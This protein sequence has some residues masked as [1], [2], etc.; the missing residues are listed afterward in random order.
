MWQLFISW[1]FA[2][3]LIPIVLGIEASA[4]D[5]TVSRSEY[6]ALFTFYN[7]T[8]GADWLWLNTTKYGPVWNFQQSNG[9]PVSNPCSPSWQGLQCVCAAG[10]CQVE[11]IALPDY[12]L[13]GF[14]A[15]SL[16]DFTA[17]K[18]LNL[19]HNVELGGYFPVAPIFPSTIESID[20]SKTSL[21][22]ALPSYLW[23]LSHLK[24]LRISDTNLAGQLSPNVA[25]LTSIVE[26]DLGRNRLDGSIPVEVCQLAT[27]ET[28]KLDHNVLSGTVFAQ[29]TQ[30]TR[31]KHLHWQGNHISGSL[32]PALA[33]MTALEDFNVAYNLINGTLPPIGRPRTLRTLNVGFNLLTG[34]LPSYF[35]T[36]DG[37]VTLNVARNLLRSSAPSFSVDSSVVNLIFDDNRFTGTIPDCYYRHMPRLS[38]L[39]LQNNL[40]HGTLPAAI[41]QLTALRNFYVGNNY[42]VSSLPA[43]LFTLTSLSILSLDYNFFNGSLSS[44]VSRLASLRVLNVA[45][46]EMTGTVPAAIGRLSNM[47]RL[48]LCGNHFHGAIP[49]DLG[50]LRLLRYL[51]LNANL[52]TGTIPASFT[53]LTNL[54]WFYASENQLS[55]DL[56]AILAAMPKLIDVVMFSNAF[57][58]PLPYNA[59]W[60]DL[61]SLSFGFNYLT[62]SLRLTA[63]QVTKLVY[64]DLSKNLLSTTLPAWTLQ[65]RHLSYFYMNENFVHGTLPQRSVTATA[66][67][68]LWMDGNVLTGTLPAAIGN[69]SFLQLLRVGSNFL[70]GTVP[71]SLATLRFMET[72]FLQSN[73]FSGGI[74]ALCDPAAQRRLKYIDISDNYFA[75]SLPPAAFNSTSLVSFAAATNCFSGS[76]P[77][78]LCLAT[79]LE[80]L[81]LD[82][83]ST[84]T[85]CQ[86]AIFA[87][88][89]LWKSSASPSAVHSTSRPRLSA[90]FVLTK[91]LT[92]GVPP[93]LFAMPRL[94]LLHLSGNALT[95]SLPP[96]VAVSPSLR[97]VSVANNQLS[98][99][100]PLALQ[101]QAFQ[102]LDVSYNKFSGTLS[103]A[104]P[105]LW[106]NGSFLALRNRLSGD[107]PASLRLALNVSILEGNLFS[108]DSLRRDLPA[109]DPKAASYSCGSD[110][111]NRALILWVCL[112]P[113]L[114][115]LLALLDRC[116]WRIVWRP[117]TKATAT[118]AATVA[119]AWSRLRRVVRLLMRW[120]QTLYVPLQLLLE[121]DEAMHR[122]RAS[123][124]QRVGS[125]VLRSFIAPLAPSTVAGTAAAAPD[126][127]SSAREDA[128]SF[129][130]SDNSESSSVSALHSYVWGLSPMLLSGLAPG[131]GLFFVFVALLSAVW[132]RVDYYKRVILRSMY[133]YQLSWPQLSFYALFA[134]VDMAILLS[135][136]VL[137]VLAVPNARS[138]V[139]FLSEAGLAAFKVAWNELVVIRGFAV[140]KTAFFAYVLGRGRA[141]TDATD[142]AADAASAA[143][144]LPAARHRSVARE[145]L[146]STTQ[147]RR[148][149]PQYGRFYD[150]IVQ[151][152]IIIANLLLMPAVATAVAN[153]NCFYNV[154]QPPATVA[155]G[156]QLAACNDVVEFG[157]VV[158]CLGRTAVYDSVTYTA[159]FLYTY[160]CSSFLVI[161]YASVYV[162][163]VVLVTVLA[164]EESLFDKRQLIIRLQSYLALLLIFGVLFPPMAVVVCVGA[165]MMM[166]FE[167]VLV[168]HVLYTH[169]QR[170]G[171]TDADGD[172]DVEAATRLTDGGADGAAERRLRRQFAACA[173]YRLFLL[174]ENA[175]VLRYLTNPVLVWMLLTV[176]S[177]I[178]GYLL[179]D[180]MGDALV[181]DGADDGSATA[182]AT[183]SHGA[184][185]RLVVTLTALTVLWP[186]LLLLV[187]LWRRWR[188]RWRCGGGG[189]G[190]ATKAAD[191]GAAGD[192]SGGG[193][194]GWSADDV[195]EEIRRE[196]RRL[197][198]T[199]RRLFHEEQARRRQWQLQQ[200]PL[201]WRSSHHQRQPLSESHHD[202][203]AAAAAVTRASHSSRG[204]RPR[205]PR[206]HRRRSTVD[207]LW[208][209]LL[210]TA[211]EDAGGGG[212]AR[213]TTSSSAAMDDDDDAHWSDAARDSRALRLSEMVTM[214]QS[215]VSL[216]STASPSAAAASLAV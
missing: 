210:Q 172:G 33:N 145:R 151:L 183:L 111:T 190:E 118:V 148:D 71:A 97:N 47:T 136:N 142:G 8:Q 77:A 121:E 78:E 44:N 198:L 74:E 122:A 75:G 177:S 170:A 153:A 168:G 24:T 182:H 82:G 123:L 13:N 29:L 6:D 88:S 102:N 137:Y 63:K 205:P 62:G 11:S 208:S 206:A 186:T 196:R 43:E 197:R 38:F 180:T 35:L 152:A 76:L 189:G 164:E 119:A 158:V 109:H 169:S 173:R 107:V 165:A 48:Y 117:R 15:D 159:P 84:A 187:S 18:S 31:L 135:V 110:Q 104:I 66:L 131:Y 30:L 160:Q 163:F 209:E 147:R 216:A 26:L 175:E 37:L 4:W 167:E 194:G 125:Q 53:Q 157:R 36:L 176:V 101:R 51:L 42:L 179:F 1:I 28:L 108:C 27:L 14:L 193:G 100:L 150:L 46:N 134:L 21:A 113:A 55:G 64:V 72:L 161:N 146:V 103:A 20:L 162:Y 5:L 124:F 80:D 215:N 129:S 90:A 99:P 106:A 128:S 188:T 120:R 114:L 67:V 57:T 40:F 19:S 202:A 149:D 50:D 174:R 52:L 201:R 132:W 203:A 96:D 58:G 207:H 141:A 7:A 69:C 34:S 98:G 105:P 23:T 184:R 79:Q 200:Q 86:R 3:W 81:V 22:G 89:S 178:Y 133:E 126:R 87:S 214:R 10:A 49:A 191:G 2:V 112:W 41:G 32:P 91:R 211:Q 83:A 171:D 212:G 199:T 166:F 85:R 139:L 156:F 92:H 204:P 39:S 192:W 70:S 155:G 213:A 181:A 25:N 115:V 17:L 65:A 9:E 61:L 127:D 16:R 154:L 130:R 143:S 144:L 94:Q 68:E 73:F 195:A 95:G 60:R 138:W 93:C 59:D 54:G 12:N 140:G 185:W 45:Y 116:L 56:Y